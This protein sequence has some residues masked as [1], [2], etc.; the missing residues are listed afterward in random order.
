MPSNGNNLSHLYVMWS[1]SIMF[2]LE[3]ITLVQLAELLLG[4]AVLFELCRIVYRLTF[5]PLA[6]FPGPKLA[7]ATNM[8]GASIDLLG[9]GYIRKLPELHAR[10]GL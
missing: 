10:Y 1:Q 8:Y 4:A 7:A 2:A 3:S 6:K 9:H 5:H